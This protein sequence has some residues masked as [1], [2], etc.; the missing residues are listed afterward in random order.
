MALQPR[1]LRQERIDLGNPRSNRPND[2]LAL[3]HCALPEPLK[4]DGSE[5]R[6]P[7]P[8]RDSPAF[9]VLHFGTPYLLPLVWFDLVQ[10]CRDHIEGLPLFR[11]VCSMGSL[12]KKRRKKMSKH[13]YRKRLKAN[14]HKRKK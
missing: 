12:V 13:K 3:R 2:S 7:S 14:R 5:P 6:A 8:T 11:E 1:S 4:P 9:P 10:G